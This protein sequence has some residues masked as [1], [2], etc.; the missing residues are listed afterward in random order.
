MAHLLSNY[1]RVQIISNCVSLYLFR[2][3][4][5]ISFIYKQSW[6]LTLLAFFLLS[7]IDLTITNRDYSI[8]NLVNSFVQDEEIIPE[9]T[10]SIIVISSIAEFRY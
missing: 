1:P 5:D 8:V 4:E 6:L 7:N 2:T 3:Y 9:K 10:F